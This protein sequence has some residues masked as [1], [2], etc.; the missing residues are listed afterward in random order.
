[1]ASNSQQHLNGNQ[2]CAVHVETTGIDPSFH[3]ILQLC[4]LPLDSELK[5]RKDVMPFYMNIRPNHPER[6]DKKHVT[7]KHERL[8]QILN[9]SYPSDKTI[10][11][12]IE[13]A[14]T[15]LKL[16]FTKWGTRKKI[17]TLSY[18]LDKAFLVSWL[19]PLHYTEFFHHD[20]R[21]LLAA[22]AFLNE[23]AAFHANIV[24]FFKLKLPWIAHVLC[25]DSAYYNKD[26]LM[27]CK[28]I[29]ECYKAIALKGLIV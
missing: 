23:Q 20:H 27:R 5:P 8:M 19:G 10:D 12:F 13:W 6:I 4:L 22:C 29:A 25:I 11:L 17:I 24:P 2:I 26:C 15:K 21:D 18:D 7:Y 1:M 28:V 9:M 3:E 16:P 14:T